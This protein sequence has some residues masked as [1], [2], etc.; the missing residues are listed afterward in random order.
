M[1]EKKIIPFRIYQILM[2]KS[3]ENHPL[4]HAKI[5]D[6]LD[7][8]YELKIERKAV[9]RSLA[10]LQDVGL[11]IE[12]TGNGSYIASREFEPSEL[13]LLI[14]S[15]LASRH[16]NE[17][18]SRDLIDKLIKLGGQYFKGH[19]KN[20]YS[21]KEWQKSENQD[22]FYN[23]DIIDEAI[24]KNKQISF[25]YN[26]FGVDKKLH[27]TY[28]HT[29]SPYQMVLHNGRYYLMA[30]NMQWHSVNYFRLDKI[31]NIKILENSHLAPIRE[32]DG[33][34]NGIDYKEIASSRPYLFTDKPKNI[35][36]KC[37]KFLINEVIDWFGYDVKISELDEENVLVK[38]KASE[39]AM[40]FWCLQYAKYATVLK[41]ESL[42]D[43][44]KDALSIALLA[45]NK[46]AE[47]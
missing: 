20:V 25:D 36:I 6:I 10:L 2:E 26:K 46:G 9:G 31:K 37:Q 28:T 8:E 4:T 17:K 24:A 18:H 14:D 5:I 38:L 15:V 32:L 27:K 43:R 45:Y 19:I 47:N 34:Q 35:E 11:D 41:P 39:A 13:R 16:I 1:E 40:E 42:R 23:I 44:V 29:V 7:R 33:Y 12:S 30:Q 21:I 3:D 22:L